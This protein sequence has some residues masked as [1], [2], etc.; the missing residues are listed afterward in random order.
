MEWEAM[1][2]ALISLVAIARL[3]GVI[4]ALLSNVLP[5]GNIPST[6]LGMNRL[7]MW[8]V[9]ALCAVIGNSMGMSIGVLGIQGA[10]LWAEV[11]FMMAAVD[12]MD[13]ISRKWLL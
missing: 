5:S 12:T 9:A 4:S 1:V 2:L 10:D 11:I 3:S 8:V 6:S 7:V 13:A